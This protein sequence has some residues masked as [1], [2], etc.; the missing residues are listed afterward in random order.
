ME[1]KVL[2]EDA[3]IDKID[4]EKINKLSNKA[5]S[6]SWQLDEQLRKEKEKPS[7]KEPLNPKEPYTYPKAK[8]DIYNSDLHDISEIQTELNFFIHTVYC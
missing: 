5:R 3:T 1:I 6:I 7:S 8:S 2:S 4:W